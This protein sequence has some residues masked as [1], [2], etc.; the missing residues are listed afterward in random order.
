MTVLKFPFDLSQSESEI[1]TSGIVVERGNNMKSGDPILVNEAGE[2][3]WRHGTFISQRQI[4]CP[5]SVTDGDTIYTVGIGEKHYFDYREEEVY[6]QFVKRFIPL[7]EEAAKAKHDAELMPA[8]QLIQA[9]LFALLPGEK[10]EVVDGSIHGFNGW[11]TLDPVIYETPRIGAVQ[12]TAGWQV[13]VVHYTHQTRNQPEEYEPVEVETARDY[14]AAVRL[15]I[16]TLFQMKSAAYWQ[17]LA[18]E[19]QEKAWAEGEM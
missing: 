1:F 3:R 9:A 17:N 10:I 16:D 6:P 12:E 7:A 5:G 18:D 13:H 8:Y 4:D 19:A 2:G 15:F 11:I 14:R